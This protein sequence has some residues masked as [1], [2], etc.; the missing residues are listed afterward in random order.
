MMG[1]VDI[2]IPWVDSS[3][4]AWRAEKALYDKEPDEATGGDHR[5]RDWGLLK[6]FFR[7]IEQFMPWVRTVHFVTWG[8]TPEWLDLSHPKLHLVKHSDYIPQEFLPTFSSHTIELNFHRIEG[9]SE[10]F[11]YFNDDMYV[12][13]AVQEHDYFDGML[14]R[15]IAALN[16]HCY[17]LSRPV[18]L[19]QINDVGVINE[20]FNFKKSVRSNWMKWFTPQNRSAILRTLATIGCP[21]FPGFYQ[22]HCAQPILK[23]TIN[24]V[25]TAEPDILTKTC[26]HRFREPTDVNQWVFR[27]WQIASGLFVSRPYKDTHAYYCDLQKPLTT[28][29]QASRDIMRQRFKMICINDVPMDQET[30]SLAKSTLTNAFEHILPTASSFELD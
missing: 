10:R 26:S 14:P 17:S 2:V 9:L 16:V 22:H 27:E 11:I 24:E 13:K 25:W 18:D 19:I 7:G 23:S 8:H 28:I 6:Y 12:L 30:F 1:P 21:R 15:D 5:Y 3:D 20:H 29:E 4:S